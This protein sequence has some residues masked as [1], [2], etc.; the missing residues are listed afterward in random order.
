MTATPLF[1]SLFAPD[2]L[3]PS[4]PDTGGAFASDANSVVGVAAEAASG[5]FVPPIGVPRAAAAIDRPPSLAY[6]ASIPPIGV[7]RAT[8]AIDRVPSSAYPASSAYSPNVHRQS[9]QTTKAGAVDSSSTSAVTRG[10]CGRQEASAEN[11]DAAGGSSD[12]GADSALPFQGYFQQGTDALVRWFDDS[13]YECVVGS[14][15]IDGTHGTLCFPP[16]KGCSPFSTT[17]IEVCVRLQIS[18]RRKLLFVTNLNELVACLGLLL[19]KSFGR[20]LTTLQKYGLS[21]R[22]LD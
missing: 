19:T 12:S 20:R 2:T 18:F 3:R 15:N 11:E 8:A 22:C 6:P 4:S 16:T 10:L 9:L 1:F 5:P 7:P 13:W 14:V 17:S 21:S